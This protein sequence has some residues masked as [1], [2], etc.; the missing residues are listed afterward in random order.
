MIRVVIVD[1]EQLVRSGL[2]MILSSADDIEVV[3]EASDGAGAAGVVRDV[4][5]DVVL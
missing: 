2:Q 4:A 3:G 1:D 5:P